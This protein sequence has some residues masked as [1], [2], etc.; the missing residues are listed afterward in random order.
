MQLALECWFADDWAYACPCG[1]HIWTSL[2][3]LYRMD[4]EVPANSR[5]VKL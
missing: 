3:S 1:N 5:S 2:L 4:T